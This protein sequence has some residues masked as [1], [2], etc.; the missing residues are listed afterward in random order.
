MSLL[1]DLFIVVAVGTP[2]LVVWL[3]LVGAVAVLVVDRVVCRPK[4]RARAD[5]YSLRERLARRAREREVQ[6]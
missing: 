2:L 6:P 3:V 1:R 4:R 5:F